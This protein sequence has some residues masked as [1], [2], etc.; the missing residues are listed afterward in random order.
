MIKAIA[1]D[2]EPVALSIIDALAKDI[3][4]LSLEKTFTDAFEAISFIHEN[5]IDLLF[6]DIKMPDISGI[7]FY[8]S[9]LKKPVVVFTT[10]YMQHAVKSY[11]LDAI[12]YLLKPFSPERFLKACR[13]V[14][15]FSG[16]AAF[17]FEGAG[18]GSVFKVRI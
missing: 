8:Q 2:D 12:D 5:E 18:A 15:D 9:L 14:G 11:E 3:P 1:I 6:L 10:A 16:V 4:F 13:K 7:D 17:G